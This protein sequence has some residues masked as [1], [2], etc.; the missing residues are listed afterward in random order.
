ML[1]RSDLY[2]LL[3]FERGYILLK[4]QGENAPGADLCA[5]PKFPAQ[6]FV[7]TLL[8]NTT[9]P[10]CPFQITGKVYVE[11]PVCLAIVESQKIFAKFLHFVVLSHGGILNHQFD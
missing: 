7:D 3:F 4:E 10:I 1:M 5:L 9:P 6:K 2:L 11:P 8:E